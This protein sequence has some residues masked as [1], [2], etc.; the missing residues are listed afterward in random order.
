MIDLRPELEGAL[1]P[2]PHCPVCLAETEREAVVI[3]SEAKPWMARFGV[4]A[5]TVEVKVW[6]FTCPNGDLP[7]EFAPERYVP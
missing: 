7:D 5:G 2:Y 6:K 4:S 1:V 3:V